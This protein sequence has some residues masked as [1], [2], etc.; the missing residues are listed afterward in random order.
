MITTE[1]ETETTLTTTIGGDGFHFLG[2][3]PPLQACQNLLFESLD[4]LQGRGFRLLRE[5]LRF[6][7][8][9][10]ADKH[11]SEKIDWEHYAE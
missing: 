9:L 5:G 3:N 11:R 1:V 8:Q 2:I 7:P 10:N 4:P 6:E